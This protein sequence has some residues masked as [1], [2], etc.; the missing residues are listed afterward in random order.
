MENRII[1]TVSAPCGSGKTYSTAQH[2]ALNHKLKRGMFVICSPTMALVDQTTEMLKAA[3]AKNIHC[4][5]GA[6]SDNIQGEIQQAIDEIGRD[7]FGVRHR[8]NAASFGT[9]TH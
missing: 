8:A 7:G 4:L 3:R 5:Q 9:G 6:C 2:I 1:N